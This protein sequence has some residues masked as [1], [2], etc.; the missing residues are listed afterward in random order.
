MRKP[1]L[2][3][4]AAALLLPG[5]LL[6]PVWR[7][8]GLGAD[9]DDILYYLPARQFLHDCVAAGVWP[10]INPATGLGRPFIADPQNAVFY[11]PTWLFLILP[12]DVAYPVSL[13]AHFS[14]ALWGMYR[15]LRSKRLGRRAALFGGVAFAFCGWMLAHRAH[16]AMH[17]A[18]AWTPWVFGRMKRLVECGGAGRVAAAAACGAM[19][20]FAGHVQ[21]VA[22]TALGTLVVT[23]ARTRGG[24][25]THDTPAPGESSSSASARVAHAS[26]GWFV[27]PAARWALGWGMAGGLF[28]VQLLPTL[29]YVRAC[30]RVD[31][32]YWDFTENSWHP[33]AATT[34]VAPMLLG[35][36]TPNVFDQPW[37]GPSHQVEQFAY[38]G[39]VCL[40]LAGLALRGPWRADARRREWVVLL[41]F[42]LLLALGKYGPLCPL[43]YWLPGSNLFRVPA[44]GLL[45]FNMAMAVLA[46]VTVHDLGAALSVRRARLRAW[47]L[48]WARRPVVVAALLVGACLAAGL[49]A[50]PWL[51]ESRRAAAFASLRPWGPAVLVPLGVVM[52]SVALLRFVGRRWDRPGFLWWLVALVAADLGIIGWTL[53]VPYGTSRRELLDPGHSADWLRQV[54]ESGGRLWVVTDTEG[55]YR[56]PLAKAAANTNVLLG[57]RTLT[58]YGPLQPSVLHR[59]FHFAAWG[60]TDHAAA[61]LR[62]TKWM[63]ACNV[64]WVLVCESDLP[65]PAGCEP[66]LMTVEGWRLF[67]NPAAGGYAFLEDAGASAAVRAVEHT[68]YLWTTV[69]DGYD[70][71]GPLG[72][73]R[74][75][76]SCVALP[77]WTATV[78]G[79]RAQVDVTGEGLLSVIVPARAVEVRWEYSPPGLIAGL[80]IST[81]C[82]AGLIAWMVLRARKSIAAPA[83]SGSGP[84]QLEGDAGPIVEPGAKGRGVLPGDRAADVES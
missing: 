55:I 29:L 75:V 15:L 24:A 84:A 23:L 64:E 83:A 10:W 3:V 77:G 82:A 80:L 38:P 69:A 63:R 73:M 28:A 49:L 74:V 11:P 21:I 19:Q 59:V 20:A 67:R 2:L 72:R 14:V 43:L 76:L 36:R 44:R 45:L 31:R 46:A 5:V 79:Q 61:L 39:I 40:I 4:L 71:R 57:L 65:D 1:V 53:D 32:G 7:L 41:G 9:E 34:W 37:W 42:A 51:T 70:A 52:A 30:T 25:A 48:D 33:L 26:W 35:Q 54:R 68:P 16:F 27:R 8:G 81:G 78:D 66:V 58:D 6:A 13:W 22:L 62:D 50:L 12:V 60:V 56:D 17:A 47:L 18:A